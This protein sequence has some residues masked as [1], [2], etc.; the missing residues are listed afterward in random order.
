MKATEDFLDDL[1]QYNQTFHGFFGTFGTGAGSQIYYLQTALK[2]VELEKITLIGE[3][4]GSESWSVRDLFQR[5]VDI[6]RVTNS[7]IPYFRDDQKVK[8]FNPLTLTILPFDPQSK[9][10]RGDLPQI[11][12]KSYTEDTR[13]WL[14][15]EMPGVYRFRHI[16]DR[17]DA[18]RLDLND[19]CSKVVA[20]DGQHRLSALKRFLEDSDNSDGQSEFLKWTIPVVIFS[21]RALGPDAAHDRILD[22]VRNIFVYINTQA[23]TPNAARQI[24]LSD[25]SIN[26]ICAQEIL[27]FSH[28]NDVKIFEDRDTS[29]MPL[30]FYDWRGE[31]VDEAR[32]KSPGALKTIE[33]IRDWLDEYLLGKDFSPKQ[34][35][36]LGIDPVSPLHNIFVRERSDPSLVDELREKI[37]TTFLPGF[38]HVL[39]G[40][41]PYS[42]YIADLR[43]IETEFQGSSSNDVGRH[44]FHKLRF[45]THRGS[46]ILETRINK[47]LEDI[48]AKIHTAVLKIPQILQRDIGMRG[49]IAA[50]GELK[51]YYDKSK[52]YSSA[53][54]EYSDWFLIQLNAVYR[55]GWLSESDKSQ[56]LQLHIC[57]DANNTIVNYRLQDAP[58]AFGPYVALF[59]AAYSE[60]GSSGLGESVWDDV[61]TEM[62]ERL[63]GTLSRGYRKEVRVI[64]R[65]KYAN[66]SKELT[67]AVRDEANSR[68]DGHIADLQLALAEIRA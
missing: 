13:Q 32:R 24:L 64:L 56:E 62:S 42:E 9:R 23:R 50:F 59:C 68:T 3:I 57:H 20:I 61:W 58:A 45:G 8:F 48:L 35:A 7:I 15:L 6:D 21:L 25:E 43:E 17:P 53:W 11:E 28:Q 12:E 67:D 55:D 54:D 4:P 18:G 38:K 36:A 16:K 19:L 34:E 22:V 52:G 63:I 49:V 51:V 41:S 30:L 47:A 10:I 5:D 26:A 46:P 66:P 27:E 44:A 65:T 31:E 40:F 14:S 33:E 2:P 1:N 37:R 39:C 60:Q 29:I